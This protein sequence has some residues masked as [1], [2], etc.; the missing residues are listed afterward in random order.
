M[1]AIETSAIK[2]VIVGDGSVGK[3]CILMR[4]LKYI[5]IFSYTQDKFPDVYI[6]TIFENYCA[7]IQVD[8]KMINLSLWYTMIINIYNERDTAG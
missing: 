3:T 1:D 7:Q 4:L 8:N 5:N 6:P 2:L